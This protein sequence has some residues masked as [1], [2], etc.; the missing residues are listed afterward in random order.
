MGIYYGINLLFRG[1]IAL[2]NFQSA[3]VWFY[4]YEHPPRR[5]HLIFAITFASF[6]LDATGFAVGGGGPN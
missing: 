3:K 5:N 4:F 6:E 1:L 2:F